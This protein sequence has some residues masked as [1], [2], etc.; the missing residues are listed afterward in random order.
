M[1]VAQQPRSDSLASQLVS[2]VATLEGA[3]QS[4]G[5]IDLSQ[6]TWAYPLLVLPLSI[7]IHETA[8]TVLSCQPQ[9]KSY[10]KTVRFPHGVTA[11]K[12]LLQIQRNYIPISRLIAA[13][14]EGK[15]KLSTQFDKMIFGVLSAVPGSENAIYYPI[16]ELITNIFEH[17][18]KDEGWIFAQNIQRK[19]IWTFASPTQDAACQNPTET[20]RDSV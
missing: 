18:R 5:T 12:D 3:P 19:I 9:V 4:K 20:K 10:L 1:I 14:L 17:S 8:S 15:E 6:I 11:V 13:D 7:Y 2:L 16:S